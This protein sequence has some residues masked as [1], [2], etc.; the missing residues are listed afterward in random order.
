MYYPRVSEN[1]PDRKNSKVHYVASELAA[2]TECGMNTEN[3]SQRCLD[4]MSLEEAIAQPDS[5]KRC[6]SVMV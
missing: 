3:M 4:D 5:C 6:I 1:Q 2:R